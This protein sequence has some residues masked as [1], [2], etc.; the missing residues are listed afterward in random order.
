MLVCITPKTSVSGLTFA[1][2]AVSAWERRSTTE[3]VTDPALLDAVLTISPASGA[4][5]VFPPNKSTSLLPVFLLKCRLVIRSVVGDWFGID[6]A[7]RRALQAKPYHQ[8]FPA[9]FAEQNQAAR[10]C[11]QHC[12]TR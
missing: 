4:S 3:E 5:G 1:G 9:D 12:T 2:A 8:T 10:P 11:T 7:R 6:S